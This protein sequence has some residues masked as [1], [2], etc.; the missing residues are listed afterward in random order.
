MLSALLADQREYGGAAKA[1]ERHVQQKQQKWLAGNGG[2][3]FN[4]VTSP[5]TNTSQE[6]LLSSKTTAALRGVLDQAS[7]FTLEFWLRHR[8]PVGTADTPILNIGT[9]TGTGSTC[10][11]T[12]SDLEVYRTGSKYA[13][14]VSTGSLQCVVASG[15]AITDDAGPV[16]VVLTFGFYTTAQV[17][18]VTLHINGG[19]PNGGTSQALLSIK[20]PATKKADGTYA[21]AFSTA[22]KSA[23]YL[24]LMSSHRTAASG[25]AAFV[26]WTGDLYLAALYARALT[27]EEITANFKALWPNNAP[28]V[29]DVAFTVNEDGEAGDHYDTPEYYLSA[30]PFADLAVLTLPAYDFEADAAANN[31]TAV[32]NASNPVIAYYVAAAPLAGTL[33]DSAGAAIVAS[34]STPPAALPSGAVRY[35]PAANESS[36]GGA[37][38]AAFTFYAVDGA[39]ARS[40]GTATA[41]LYVRAKNDP[42]AAAAAAFSVP[43]SSAAAAD[44]VFCVN[45]TDPDAGDA[46]THAVLR[47]APA[48]GRLFAVEAAGGGG[49]QQAT[50]ME[51]AVNASFGS[52]QLCAAYLYTGAAVG[53]GAT[54]EDGFAFA[55]VDRDGAASAA[56]RAAVTVYGDAATV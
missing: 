12:T 46:V 5:A 9:V 7:G 55:V 32:Y 26:P 30:V 14:A 29:A 21:P 2:G 51:L 15:G 49:A 54:A 10:G 22:W 20:Y 35:R 4:G 38:Y 23:N 53:A 3:G 25:I 17:M 45:G 31:V 44:T 19:T 36:A 42:P 18:N 11:G 50:A 47:S 43:A 52:A 37:A 1:T 13:V 6:R 16:H 8:A 27:A 28:S 41:T 34:L 33:Y 40:A 39:G 48:R 56:Q 24:H